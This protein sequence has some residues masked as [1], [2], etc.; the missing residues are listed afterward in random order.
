MVI[1]PEQ[2]FQCLASCQ[3]DAIANLVESI[4]A[5]AHHV[6]DHI[7]ITSDPCIGQAKFDLGLV[8]IELFGDY[9]RRGPN[10]PTTDSTTNRR[11]SVISHAQSE[12]FPTLSPA[13]RSAEN[14]GVVALP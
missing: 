9:V 8:P 10:S 14:I 12:Y 7:Q 6:G 1:R 11:S 4:T 13:R 5:S 2:A 3:L